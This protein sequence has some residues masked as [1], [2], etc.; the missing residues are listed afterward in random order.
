MTIYNFFKLPLTFQRED[1]VRGNVYLTVQG[2][3]VA[4]T[5]YYNGGQ[6]SYDPVT[7]KYDN[8]G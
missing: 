5:S 4:A 8:K 7:S 1:M 3:T 6:F 2:T